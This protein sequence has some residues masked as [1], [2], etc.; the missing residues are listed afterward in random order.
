MF[1]FQP[2]NHH[3]RPTK[4]SQ[5]DSCDLTTPSTVIDG[6]AG[7]SFCRAQVPLTSNSQ[8]PR[9]LPALTYEK[10]GHLVVELFEAF[11]LFLIFV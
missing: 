6:I 5:N 9:I 4:T 8:H 2:A 10:E 7:L 11:L 3:T 1:F